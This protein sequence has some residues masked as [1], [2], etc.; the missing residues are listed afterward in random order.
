MTRRRA[1]GQL[2]WFGLFR[3]LGMRF[4][5]GG[6]WWD[7]SVCGQ[8]WPGLDRRRKVDNRS[9]NANNCKPKGL[10]W[11]LYARARGSREGKR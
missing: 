2:R 4:G 9:T 6:P 10:L 7:R 11:G 8:Y 3:L 1:G 5:W